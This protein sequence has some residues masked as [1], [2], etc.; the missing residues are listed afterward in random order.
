MPAKAAQQL[1]LDLQIDLYADGLVT[2]INRLEEKLVHLASYLHS[3]HGLMLAAKRSLV[4]CYSQVQYSYLI[5]DS[6]L[7]NVDFRFH[8]GLD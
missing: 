3:N 4:N 8:Q 7:I 6:I 5:C 2:T 1:A